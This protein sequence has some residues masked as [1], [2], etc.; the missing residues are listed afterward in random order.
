MSHAS[1]Q[2]A[3]RRMQACMQS[4]TWLQ[5]AMLHAHASYKGAETETDANLTKDIESC[6]VMTTLVRARAGQIPL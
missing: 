1:H 4:K 5:K 2:L 6:C 3:F